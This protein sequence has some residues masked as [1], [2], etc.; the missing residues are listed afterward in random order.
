METCSCFVHKLAQATWYL[1]PH[2]DKFSS[3]SIQLPDRFSM[4]RG[5][6]DFK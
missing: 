6:N 5:Y 2:P 3:R 4:Y 1:D